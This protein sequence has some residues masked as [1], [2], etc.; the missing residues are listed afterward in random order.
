VLTADKEILVSG[1]WSIFPHRFSRTRQWVEGK[2]F[3]FEVDI[4]L[5]A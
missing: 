3:A 2:V 1:S 4:D 5:T